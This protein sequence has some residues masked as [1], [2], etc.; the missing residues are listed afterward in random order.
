MTRMRSTAYAVSGLALETDKPRYS[1][2][3]SQMSSPQKNLRGRES[4]AFSAWSR[5][6]LRCAS[7]CCNVAACSPFPPFPLM[8][9][10]HPCYKTAGM[11]LRHDV[12]GLREIQMAGEVG[13][14]VITTTRLIGNAVRLSCYVE[15][16]RSHRRSVV[17]RQLSIVDCQ[18][19]A[20]E[21]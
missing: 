1:E 2:V 11:L 17:N 6:M 18:R 7:T 19:V 10:V 13:D 4:V 20:L 14:S 21:A 15:S 9:D 12:S 5:F 3:P 8:Y 16:T